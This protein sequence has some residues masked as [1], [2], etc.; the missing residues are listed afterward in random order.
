MWY[1][2]FDILLILKYKRLYQLHKIKSKEY[3]FHI[4]TL[5]KANKSRRGSAGSAPW[6]CYSKFI[7]VITE[8][9]KKGSELNFKSSQMD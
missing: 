6:T 5:Y 3:R 7:E 4:Y 1:I 9:V 2:L 8:L